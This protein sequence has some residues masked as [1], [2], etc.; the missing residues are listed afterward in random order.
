M[1]SLAELINKSKLNQ[2]TLTLNHASVATLGRSGVFA[3]IVCL[4]LTGN[5]LTTL[6]G[7]E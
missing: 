7:I 3:H 1:T 4:H 2:G 5:L 6:H